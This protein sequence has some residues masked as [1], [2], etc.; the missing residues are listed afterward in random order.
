MPLLRVNHLG[1]VEEYGFGA[2]TSE[3]GF[4]VGIMVMPKPI[5][6]PSGEIITP[7]SVTQKIALSDKL[8]L[9]ADAQKTETEKAAQIADGTRFDLSLAKIASTGA[10]DYRLL[11]QYIM[12]E[13]GKLKEFNVVSNGFSFAVVLGK[14]LKRFTLS[15]DKVINKDLQI[16]NWVRIES[17]IVNE[18]LTEEDGVPIS[19]IDR[20]RFVP[21][22]TEMRREYRTIDLT[23]GLLT[24]AEKRQT[25]ILAPAVKV[26]A[27]PVQAIAYVEAL[28]IPVIEPKK[29]IIKPSIENIT[30]HPMSLYGLI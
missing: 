5:T 25:E 11:P 17:S 21:E 16:G 12:W 7:L 18:M 1:Q 13:Y 30:K 8:A 4:R 2:G 3:I 22:Q 26:I 28:P 15:P 19:S 9:F 10:L 24:K 27:S 14:A 29:E 20:V 23:T 6:L